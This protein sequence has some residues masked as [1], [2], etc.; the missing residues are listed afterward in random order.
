MMTE[1]VP[2][3]KGSILKSLAN[4]LNRELTAAQMTEVMDALTADER[5]LVSGPILVSQH[6]PEALATA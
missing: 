3:I 5:A 4:Y 6:V 2:I 1:A